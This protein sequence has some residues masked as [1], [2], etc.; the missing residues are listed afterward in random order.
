M[1]G[2]APVTA[3]SAKTWK[4]AQLIGGILILLGFGS[5][6][7]V[8]GD[9]NPDEKHEFASNG[10]NIFVFGLGLW[11]VGKVGHWWNSD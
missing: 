8:F 11:F 7:A 6:L 5:C 10:V 3:R 2:P 1:Q 4:T 9:G